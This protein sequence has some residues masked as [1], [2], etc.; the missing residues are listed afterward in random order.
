M[1]ETLSSWTQLSWAEFARPAPPSERQ[2]FRRREEDYLPESGIMPWT[3][4]HEVCS[5]SA[6]SWGCWSGPGADLGHL[7][8]W[9]IGRNS[10]FS[11]SA[12][13]KWSGWIG[14]TARVIRGW[15]WSVLSRWGRGPRGKRR[16]S[17]RGRRPR[18]CGRIGDV[19][20]RWLGAELARLRHA[21]RWPHPSHCVRRSHDPLPASSLRRS[22]PPQ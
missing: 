17:R 11:V 14:W 2:C 18:R 3:R 5:S 8:L 13:T 20:R 1:L 9:E 12:S 16:R 19:G 22:V 15:R 4:P 7:W 6:E 21:R 10:G